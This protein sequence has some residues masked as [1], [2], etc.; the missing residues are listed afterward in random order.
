MTEDFTIGQGLGN[1]FNGT[2]DDVAIFN[3]TLSA[4]EVQSVCNGALH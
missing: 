1:Y 3:R 2:I 4:A